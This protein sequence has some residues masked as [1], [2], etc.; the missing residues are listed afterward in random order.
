MN[1]PIARRVYLDQVP[2]ELQRENRWVLWRYELRKESTKW[3]KI[4]CTREGYHAKSNDPATWTTFTK[5]AN[6]YRH[7]DGFDGIGFCLGD[8]WAGIDLDHCRN[9]S[10]VPTSSASLP[11][12]ARLADLHVYWEVS[13]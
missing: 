11:V 13:P 6:A 7:R 4:L 8:G 3:S 9:E 1:R 5:A 2:D 12:L 10:G